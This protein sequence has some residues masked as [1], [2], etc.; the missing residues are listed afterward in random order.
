MLATIPL[1]LF[2]GF[3]NSYRVPNSE[4]YSCTPYSRTPSR[5]LSRSPVYM[6]V[7]ECTRARNQNA[8]VRRSPRYEYEYNY[9]VLYS[10]QY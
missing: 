2:N 6:V 3:Y 5:I 10:Y 9:L 7:S 8:A 1:S 4:K